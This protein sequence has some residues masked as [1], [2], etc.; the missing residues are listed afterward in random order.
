LEQ[1]LAVGV[2]LFA[3]LGGLC[4]GIAAIHYLRSK[5]V[6]D[7]PRISVAMAAF[8]IQYFLFCTVTTLGSY[9]LLP[10]VLLFLTF[11]ALLITIW[12][13]VQDHSRAGFRI[14]LAAF[15]T[16]GAYVCKISGESHEL[17][18]IYWWYQHH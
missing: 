18:K 13:G 16:L 2:I 1:L 10:T 5:E 6:D 17:T 11:M 15:F 9:L 4:A 8:A 14:A 7:A 12:L 3:S